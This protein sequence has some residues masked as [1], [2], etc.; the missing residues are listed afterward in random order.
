[1]IAL[2]TAMFFA[3]INQTIVGVALPRIIAN[4]GGMNYYTWVITI[5]LLTTA[6]STI[7]VGKLSDIYGRKP[8]F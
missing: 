2:M 4:L 3:A 8:F 6:I 1:M 5:Y 7:L